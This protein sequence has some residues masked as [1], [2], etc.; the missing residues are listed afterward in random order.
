MLRFGL[1]VFD[2]CREPEVQRVTSYSSS[3]GKLR[4]RAAKNVEHLAIVNDEHVADEVGSSTRDT[5]WI[6]AV[7]GR[8]GRQ[9]VQRG[10][11][12]RLSA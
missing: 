10:F 9:E 6:C 3:T 12:L 7:S 4:M 5:R 2:G 1:T 11:A 8:G